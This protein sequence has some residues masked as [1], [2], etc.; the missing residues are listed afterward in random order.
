MKKLFNKVF[1]KAKLKI[2]ILTMFLVNTIP[3]YAY[4]ADAGVSA[5]SLPQKILRIVVGWGSVIGLI[6]LAVSLIKDIADHVKGQTSILKVVMKILFV[7]VLLGVMVASLTYNP[8][9]FSGLVDE[10]I[11]NLPSSFD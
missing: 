11:S 1:I 4:A 5:E 2:L 9:T 3:R 10:T 7:L 6:I 8:E